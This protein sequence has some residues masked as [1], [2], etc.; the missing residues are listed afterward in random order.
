[1]KR[2]DK[3]FT[4]I[5]VLLAIC[6]NTIAQEEVLPQEK[7]TPFYFGYAYNNSDT[8]SY[9]STVF[10]VEGDISSELVKE[11]W[12]HFIAAN[13]EASNMTIDIAGPYSTLK[14]AKA[15]RYNYQKEYP[16]HIIE[17]NYVP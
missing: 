11:N 12:E 15:I 10:R 4:T 6:L 14:E 16:R 17:I 13:Y 3:F 2:I 1:M 7:G 9:Y 8:I 5:I